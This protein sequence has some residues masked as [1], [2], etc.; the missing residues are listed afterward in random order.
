[1]RA[2]RDASQAEGTTV[3][4]ALVAAFVLAG[5]QASERWRTAPVTCFSPAN[6]RTMLNLGDAP[7]LAVGTLRSVIQ[8]PDALPFWEF[9]RELKHV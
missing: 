1:M 3:Q 7:G 9:A 4:G 2:L 8:P 5:R 6:L